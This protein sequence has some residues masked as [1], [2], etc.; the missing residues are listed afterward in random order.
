MRDVLTC[1]AKIVRAVTWPVVTEPVLRTD[2]MKLLALKL[3]ANNTVVER[4]DSVAS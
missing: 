1:R 2:V 3:L 4:E